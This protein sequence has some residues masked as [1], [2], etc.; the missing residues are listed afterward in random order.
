MHEIVIFCFFWKSEGG[1]Q[2]YLSN[3]LTG[4]DEDIRPFKHDKVDIS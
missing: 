4:F 3:V 2:N 1:G